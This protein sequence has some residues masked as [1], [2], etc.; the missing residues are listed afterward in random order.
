MSDDKAKALQLKEAGNAAYKARNFEEAASK[1][2]EA[3]ETDKDITCVL[4]SFA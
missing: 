3:W 4:D 1:Y 2:Q